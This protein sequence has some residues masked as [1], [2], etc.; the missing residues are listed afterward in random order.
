MRDSCTLNH[1]QSE[2]ENILDTL[3]INASFIN[4]D[5]LEEKK[6]VAKLVTKKASIP[7]LN[8]EL[9]Q[10]YESKSKSEIKNYST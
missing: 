6:E 9:S 1:S 4:L 10:N 2:D 3:D 5:K 8:V 7:I